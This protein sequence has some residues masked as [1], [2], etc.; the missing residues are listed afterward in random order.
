M[1]L[2][3]PF[4]NRLPS[5]TSQ[6]LCLTAQITKLEIHARL[7]CLISQNTVSY[8]FILHQRL[9]DGLAVD[10]RVVLLQDGTLQ[11]L[12][13]LVE[14]EER[15]VQFF[16]ALALTKFIKY[17]RLFALWLRPLTNA[18]TDELRT[19]M[20]KTGVIDRLLKMVEG[21]VIGV[22]AACSVALRAFVAHSK[23]SAE[24]SFPH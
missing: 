20:L 1:M 10:V 17:G 2:V 6:G 14:S 21:D 8:Q 5:Q 7:T 11:K 23:L 3:P 19:E 15:S 12:V 22:G 13:K 24:C 9:N 4:S 16:G 18:L